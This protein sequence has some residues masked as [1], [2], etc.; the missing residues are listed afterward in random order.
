MSAP[1]RAAGRVA[2]RAGRVDQLQRHLEP[3]GVAPGAA[4]PVAALVD[5]LVDVAQVLGGVG[6]QE[7]E[8]I[9]VVRGG[10]I[11]RPVQQHPAVEEFR[12]GAHLV[13]LALEQVVDE[14][15]ATV[16]DGKVDNLLGVLDWE[17]A[18]ATNT[19]NTFTSL[20]SFE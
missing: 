16:I 6:G 7:D 3:V 10:V 13:L 11:E 1:T 2:Q 8:E 18:S 14:V 17:L 19:E 15:V 9:G 12:L 20:F 4:V 5:H